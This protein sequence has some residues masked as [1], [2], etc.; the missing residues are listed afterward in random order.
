[1]PLAMTPSKPLVDGSKYH[2]EVGIG[3]KDGT[4]FD[5]KALDFTWS[6]GEALSPTSAPIETPPASAPVSPTTDTG[7]IIAAALASAG[8][9]AV[10]FLVVPRARRRKNP[11]AGDAAK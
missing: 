4:I 2:I 9:V 10:L 11:G 3:L 7:V 5:R 1:M 6:G 8:L